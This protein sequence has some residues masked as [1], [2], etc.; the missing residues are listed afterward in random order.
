MLSAVLSLPDLLLYKLTF[1]LW[2]FIVAST[3]CP[4]HTGGQLGLCI[5][6]THVVSGLRA[7]ITAGKGLVSAYDSVP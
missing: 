3:P 5:K 4:E 2:Y 6:Q 7:G 1:F